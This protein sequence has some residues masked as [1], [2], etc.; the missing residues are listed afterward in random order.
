MPHHMTAISSQPLA[1]NGSVYVGQIQHP[2]GTS[3]TWP[4]TAQ[5]NLAAVGSFYLPR[6]ER[7]RNR[8]THKSVVTAYSCSS[9]CRRAVTAGNR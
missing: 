7:V 5:F 3:G 9:C 2:P 6:D 1:R 4:A 8:C